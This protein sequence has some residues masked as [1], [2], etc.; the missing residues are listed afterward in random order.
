M[1]RMVKPA[2]TGKREAASRGKPRGAPGRRRAPFRRA[3]LRGDQPHRHRRGRRSLAGDAELFLRLQGGPVPGRPRAGV[4]GARPRHRHRLSAG[5]RMGRFRAAG[6]R[7]APRWPKRSAPTWTSS[8]GHP[9]FQRLVQREELSGGKRLQGVERES[10]AI[11]DAFEALRSRSRGPATR[12]VRRRR[13]GPRLRLADLLSARSACD[14]HG[15]PGP[16]PRR[17]G[18]PRPSRRAGRR[19]AALAARRRLADGALVA[20]PAR[21]PG[22][23]HRIISIRRVLCASQ[24]CRTANRKWRS[25]GRCAAGTAFAGPISLRLRRRHL[26]AQRRP[27]RQRQRPSPSNSRGKTD[28]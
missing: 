14:L 13:R 17:S 19:P 18:D 3:R 21:R 26:Q 20:R 6:R 25:T 11:R 28:E 23:R 24:H 9:S 7:C 10:S 8:S 1:V 15:R 22:R 4:R 16:R 2:E 5:S 12:R 27:G